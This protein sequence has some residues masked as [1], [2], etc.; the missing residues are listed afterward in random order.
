VKPS[1][2]ASQAFL[3]LIRFSTLPVTPL[4]KVTQVLLGSFFPFTPPPMAIR[5]SRALAFSS[6]LFKGVIIPCNW[7]KAGW[8]GLTPAHRQLCFT[9]LQ[10]A[11]Q[12]SSEK[13]KAWHCHDVCLPTVG[14]VALLVHFRAVHFIWPAVL[15]PSPPPSMTASGNRDPEVCG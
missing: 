7:G 12:S 14:P 13:T 9:V 10:F 4:G 2:M 11:G 3:Q 1:I 8:G 15:L 5:G 6:S